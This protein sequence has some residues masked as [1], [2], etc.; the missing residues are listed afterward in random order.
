MESSGERDEPATTVREVLE[1]Q[2]VRLGVLF[3]S[4][5]RGTAGT[6]SDVDIAVEFNESVD[7][8]FRARLTLGADLA[9]ALGTDDVD[10]V[11]L[12]DVRLT[13]G[14]SALDRGQVLVGDPDHAETLAA[15]F[16]REQ[17]AS[18]PRERRERFDETLARLE[19]LV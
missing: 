7:D 1:A 6:H 10:V 2:A 5:A 18:T 17:E 14:Y 16:E 9:R 12:D 3:G 15:A 13:V 8:R 19:E 11:D 4:R